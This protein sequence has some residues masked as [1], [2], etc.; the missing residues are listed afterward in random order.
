MSKAEVMFYRNTFRLYHQADA[1]RVISEG[2]H[3]FYASVGLKAN[4]ILFP[5]LVDLQRIDHLGREEP[6]VRFGGCPHNVVCFGRL[7]M[8]KNV[9]FLIESIGHLRRT[10]DAHLWII[11]DG[12]QR[13]FL[14]QTSERLGLAA[15][16]T[17]LGYQENPYPLLKQGDVF[18]LT[19]VW[20][21]SPQVIVEAMILGVPVVSVDCLTGPN[22]MLGKYSE[23]GWLVPHPNDSMRFAT[24][25]KKALVQKEESQRRAAAA[26]KFAI[27]TYDLQARIDEYI[28]VF[29]RGTSI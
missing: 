8:Q 11:G 23:R 17:F 3:D 22:E 18:A 28:D 26:A 6:T 14:E 7:G 19:S 21:G 10:L 13:Q 12:D 29:F 27:D 24:V 16:I 4:V 25:L 9:G 1:I 20:E 2:I 15:H 5:N